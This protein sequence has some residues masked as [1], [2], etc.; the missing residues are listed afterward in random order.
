MYKWTL[1]IP[2]LTDFDDEGQDGENE[3]YEVDFFR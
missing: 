2:W 1:I 3:Y